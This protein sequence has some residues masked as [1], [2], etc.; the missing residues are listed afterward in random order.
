M[1]EYNGAYD[2]V[3]ATTASTSNTDAT[4]S[5]ANRNATDINTL[6][7]GTDAELNASL[8]PRRP[9]SGRQRPWIW[10]AVAIVVVAAIGAAIFAFNWASKPAPAGATKD[11]V[12]IGLKLPPTNLDIRNQSGSTLDQILIGNV[13]EGLV[14]RNAKNQVVPALAKSWDISSDGTTYT[15]HLN[16]GI[17]FSNG[18]RLDAGDAAWSI[19]ELVT[20]QYH[21]AEA[22]RNFKSVRAVDANTV[23]ITLSAPYADLLWSLAGRPG[24]VFDKDAHYDAKTA[25]LGSGPYTV[26][27]FV[28]NDSISLKANPKY[29]GANKAKTANVLIRFFADDNAAVNALKSGDVQ[30]LA[31]ISENLAA[32]FR[33]DAAN[34][35]VKAGDDTDKFV[36]A[37]NSKGAKTSDRRVRQA[38]RYAIDHKAI[39]ASR[40][41]VDKALG[42]P[43]PSLD[44]GY[45]DLTGLYPHDEAK[46]KSLL[47]EA[48][49]STSKPL[50]LSLT[51]AS[52][53]GTELGDQLRS[54]LRVV[55]IDLK[56]NVVEFSTWLQ[57]VYTNKNYDLSLVDH[58]ES[59]DFY[60]WATPTYYY[61]YDSKE[62]QA[63]Y[64]KS[65]AATTAK[66][67]EQYLAQAARIVSR[68]A[69]ADWLFNYRVT[70]AWAKG[71]EGFPVNLNQ[72]LLPLYDVVYRP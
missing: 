66:E 71:V 68:D 19:D 12:A 63:L 15:F 45:E 42:G 21:D 44:P 26:Q 29:W 32:P 58:N 23:E 55:G 30:V 28:A 38:I 54:Q 69:P 61:N 47:A 8:K 53:Y 9:D 39:I 20:R 34:Y 48:G 40:G 50:R 59:H 43:I 3:D 72:T 37:F 35:T 18:D 27:R 60:Q 4:N 56:V 24:L 57:D 6:K 49:Y 65:L 41:G 64:A 10:I 51:Y 11:T 22:L 67:S 14:A 7:S 16:T 2:D 1:T 31:P 52:T 17:T 70:T 13:Y 5:D 25:A 46:A 36:L 33:K 62:V